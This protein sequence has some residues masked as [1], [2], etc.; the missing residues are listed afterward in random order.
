MR[1]EY[2]AVH[3]AIIDDPEFRALSPEARWMWMVLRLLLGASGID[4]VRAHLP[5][6]ADATGLSEGHA[7]GARDELEE[8]NWLVREGDVLWLRNAL[9]FNPHVNPSNEKNRTGLE[10]HVSGLP[11]LQIVLDFCGYYGLEAPF[12]SVPGGP[13]NEGPSHGPSD[14]PTDGPSHGPPEA[15]KGIGNGRGSGIGSGSGSR[16]HARRRGVDGPSE[17]DGS[18][19][20]PDNM[21]E[22]LNGHASALDGFPLYRDA[23]LR[24]TLFQHYGPPGLRGRWVRLLSRWPR[25]Q[26]LVDR[27]MGRWPGDLDG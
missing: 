3:S 20:E 1:G 18:S 11:R 6:L 9:R 15:R 2:A 24:E 16:A 17:A 10:T 23:R 26:R 13:R 7:M 12:D 5:A 25:L 27:L 8:G 22:W 19:T 14:A 21:S 4:L